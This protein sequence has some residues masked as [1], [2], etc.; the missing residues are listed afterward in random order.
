MS[1]TTEV[2]GVVVH[3]RKSSKKL[4]FLDICRDEERITVLFKSWETESIVEAVKGDRK[5]HLGDKVLF[6]GY[7]ES[8]GGMFSVR[9]YDILTLWS[10]TNPGESFVPQPPQKLDGDCSQLPCKEFVNTGQCCKSQCSFLHTGDRAELIQSRVKYVQDKKERQILVHEN[11][12][13]MEAASSSQRAR[14]FAEWIV[15]KFGLGRLLLKMDNI[16]WT[17]LVSGNLYKLTQQIFKQPPNFGR[18]SAIRRVARHCRGPGR[19]RLRAQLQVRSPL[20]HHRPPAAEVPAVAAQADEE[21]PGHRGP[22]PRPGL[23]L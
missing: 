1:P 2:E 17:H 19:P 8:E 9:E 15:E 12:F 21:K 18:K 20:R 10:D 22:D 4:V 13:E 11:N 5:I 14:I 23:V 3:I 7:F 16:V 6:K